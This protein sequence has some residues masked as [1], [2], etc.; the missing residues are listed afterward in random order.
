MIID[1]V[2][3]DEMMVL[4]QPFETALSSCNSSLAESTSQH[5]FKQQQKEDLSHWQSFHQ[6]GLWC[7]VVPA[8]PPLAQNKGVPVWEETPFSYLDSIGM[9]QF[10]L[11]WRPARW[12]PR[13]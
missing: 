5:A 12:H 10:H 8:T 9:R 7:K 11:C 3:L 1:V 13:R 2:W 6:A 4:T